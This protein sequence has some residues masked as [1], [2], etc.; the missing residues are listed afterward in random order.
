[1]L[2]D[3]SQVELITKHAITNNLI[4]H[5]VCSIKYFIQPVQS[6]TE[7]SDSCLSCSQL[8]VLALSI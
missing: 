1:M 4:L 5:N 2:G 6:E 3:S 8:A 7:G